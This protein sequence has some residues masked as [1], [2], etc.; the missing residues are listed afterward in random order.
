MKFGQFFLLEKY[1]G[2]SD[3]EVYRDSLEQ[4]QVADKLGYH[5][6]WLAEHRF[7]QYGILP[8]CV[9]FGAA[10]AATTERIRIGQ[11]VMVLPFHHPINLAEQIAMLDVMSNGRLDVGVGRG[12]Q[13]LE[14]SAFDMDMDE[15]RARFE[16][17]LEIMKGLWTTDNFSYQG[18]F[19]NVVN[20]TLQPRPVQK[21]YPK[22]H[23]AV[24]RTP[25]SFEFALDN[26]YSFLIG[27][28]Y[29]ADPG[30]AEA[31]ETYNRIMAERGHVDKINDSWALVKCFVHED[32]DKAV[33]IPKE[34]WRVYSE[35]VLKHGTPKRADGSLSKDYLSY[36]DHGKALSESAKLDPREVSSVIC[37]NPERAKKRIAEMHASGIQNIIL[38]FNQGGGIPQAE[39]LKSMELFAKEVMPEFVDE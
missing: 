35:S 22:I 10:I 33:E 1:P 8:D 9:V 29:A 30:L 37:G 23:V 19:F 25:S 24:M 21:P 13:A 16:E 34:S 2:R 28:P 12:Y 27:N 32:D 5:T 36:G 17:S 31:M 18:K 3:S 38:I 7:S 6:A 20:A 26:D 14:Y 15:S 11:A 4:V 39:V